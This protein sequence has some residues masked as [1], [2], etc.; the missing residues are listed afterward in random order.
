MSS[1]VI[2]SGTERI[3][4]IA[5]AVIGKGHPIVRNGP[6]KGSWGMSDLFIP[7]EAIC[8]CQGDCSVTTA[9]I[10]ILSRREELATFA[11]EN[12]VLLTPKRAMET[13]LLWTAADSW[14][15]C[16]TRAP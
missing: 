7:D 8:I 13:I 5:E 14:V 10:R 3:A 12:L 4:S 2:T 1:D 6:L 16:T 9:S 11:E 15:E